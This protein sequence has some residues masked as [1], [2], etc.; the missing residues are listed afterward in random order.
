MVVPLPGQHIPVI[1]ARRVRVAAVPE[2]PFADHRRL[3][4]GSLQQ[5]REGLLTA[6]KFFI[7][8]PDTVEMIVF[9][10]EDDRPARRANRVGAKTVF[11]AHA[12]IGYSV[13]VWCRIYF[14]PVT[15]D[16]MGCM[17]V[18]HDKQNIRRFHSI[19]PNC[20]FVSVFFQR[21]LQFFLIIKELEH[22][23]RPEHTA[24]ADHGNGANTCRIRLA[25]TQ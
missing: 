4:T 1:K 14:T 8:R 2:V 9:T 3:I 16:G 10:C 6:V 25:F 21:R 23:Q 20:L 12:F 19:S 13:D 18:R 15:A 22:N 17:V 5:F 11:K 24:G 7:K